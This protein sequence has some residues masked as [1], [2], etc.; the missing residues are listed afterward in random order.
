MRHTTPILLC[1]LLLLPA[2]A[3]NR[4]RDHA[5]WPTIVS[6]WPAVR[7]EIERGAE[8]PMPATMMVATQ[9]IDDAV[10]A[11]DWKQ[12]SGVRWDLLEPV[13]LQ[14]IEARVNAGEVSEGVATSLRERV[15]QF[16]DAIQ[17]FQR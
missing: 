2:C 11:D 9:Q 8:S 12:L 17:E 10:S 15:A 7:A 1:C 4:A 14:G 13:A 5:L 6:T 16:S 3:G